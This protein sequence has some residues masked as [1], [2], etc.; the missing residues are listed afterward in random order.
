VLKPIQ[1]TV[2][3]G[4]LYDPAPGATEVH[5]PGLKGQ[6]YWIEKTGFGP[7]LAGSTSDLSDGGFALTTG[8]FVLNETYFIHVKRLSYT[9]ESADY[10]NGFNF[11]K[12]I[13]ALLGGLA[14]RQ[15]TNSG[16]PVL[17]F[18]N[19]TS[20][21]GRYFDG[22]HALCNV[23]NVRNIIA[24]PAI[25][26]ND[27]NLLLQ[28]M[29][30]DV[31]MRSLNAVFREKEL[32]EQVLLYDR[33]ETSV[34][35]LIPN[36]N[37]FCGIVI[38][39]PRAFDISVQIDSI[40]LFFNQD[41]DFNLYLFKGGNQ[42]PIWSLPVSAEANKHTIVDV[43][44]LILSYINDDTKGSR[45]YLGYFQRDLGAAQAIQE[46]V[47]WINTRAFAAR[48]FYSAAGTGNTIN[49]IYTPEPVL[50][51]G[52]N[53]EMSSFRDHTRQIV[54]NAN[55]FDELI[56]LQ[57][58]A[59]VIEQIMHSTRSNGGERILKEGMDKMMVY[60]DLK[61]TVP[62]SDA[63]NSYGLYQQIKKELARLHDTFFPPAKAI[64]VDLCSL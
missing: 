6:E 44:D 55:L 43:D 32:L 48:S 56:G 64:S 17:D 10:T 2:G 37:N 21:R 5:F 57:M 41:V 38:D 52:F 4:G 20:K 16:A 51:V 63:P 50:P 12:V 26:D 62:I 53:L 60:M 28:S 24:D 11:S 31:A 54:R 18:S 3:G 46:Q 42:D 45:F 36:G 13:N 15:P 61:G 25:T 9:A 1:I 23:V 40:V 58:A 29:Y 47:Y 14:W 22:F 8:T 35:Y 34:D 30:K 7:M 33:Y 49:Q 39:T 59:N 19:Y 27:F